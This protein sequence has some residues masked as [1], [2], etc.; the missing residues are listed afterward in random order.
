[1]AKKLLKS[2]PGNNQGSRSNQ[3]SNGI[4]KN[5]SFTPDTTPVTGPNSVALKPL[6]SNDQGS[7]SNQPSDNIPKRLLFPPSTGSNNVAVEDRPM[8]FVHHKCYHSDL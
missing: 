3:P 6:L 8:I 2:P 4:S 7:R 5:N 1:M